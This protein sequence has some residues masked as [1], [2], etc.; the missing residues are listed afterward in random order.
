MKFLRLKDAAGMAVKR[1]QYTAIDDATRIRALQIFSKHSQECAIQFMDY[2]IEKFPFRI[3]TV[4]TDRGHEF[5]ARFPYGAKNTSGGEISGSCTKIL[6]KDAAKSIPPLNCG[7]RL[8]RRWRDGQ[9]LLESLVRTGGV[10]MQD[11]LVQY[12]AQVR[13]VQNDDVIETLLAHGSHPTL[14]KRIGVGCMKRCEQNV[15]AFRPKGGVK[16]TG[17]LGISIVNEKAGLGFTVRK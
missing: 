15:D 5:Q 8:H 12:T 16:S 3:N 11:E 10:V 6:V 14:G 2:V 13:F 4:R 7:S 17:K 9:L 1:Y